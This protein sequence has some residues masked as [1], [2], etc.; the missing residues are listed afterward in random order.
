LQNKIM[1]KKR[2]NK[3]VGAVVVSDLHC[4]SS[5]GLWPDGAEVSYGNTIGLGNNLHQRWLWSC[6]CDAIGKAVK[7]FGDAPWALIVNGD[8]IEGRHHGTTE[9]VTAK[10]RDHAAAAVECLR[11]LA[12][13]ASKSFCVAGTECHTGDWEE[14]IAKEI[15]AKWCGDKALLELNGTLIDVAHHMPTS[16][17]AYLEAGAMSIV[18]GNARLN[19]A[20]AGHSV[21]KVFL[22]AHR[23]CGGFYSDAHALFV[24]TG[25]WQMLTRYGFKVVTDSISRPSIAILDWRGDAPGSLPAIKL[26]TYDP[27]QTNQTKL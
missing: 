20:R 2:S 7:H 10:N 26:I 16:S 3:I 24:V 15:G 12:E 5:V 6:W 1:S 14:L 18:M 11:P 27:D 17:R 22:R 8:C 21:P 13:A 4:G 25:A 23:H 19:Y 9:I